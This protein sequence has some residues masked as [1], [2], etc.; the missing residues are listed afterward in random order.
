MVSIH[1]QIQLFIINRLTGNF[2]SKKV[3]KLGFRGLKYI[4]SSKKQTWNLFSH[5]ANLISNLTN[6]ITS[7]AV[8]Q[9]VQVTWRHRRN[10]C[11]LITNEL[12]LVLEKV[13]VLGGTKLI[14]ILCMIIERKKS[15]GGIGKT[16]KVKSLLTHLM[17]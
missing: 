13:W 6:L 16:K 17:K 5:A 1:K 8:I 15:K 11:D 10:D 9:I 7:A 3:G 14:N 12:Q 2:S 4:T